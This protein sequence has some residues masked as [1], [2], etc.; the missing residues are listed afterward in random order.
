[1]SFRGR[2]VNCCNLTLEQTTEIAACADDG[3]P[4]QVPGVGWGKLATPGELGDQCGA[5]TTSQRGNVHQPAATPATCATMAI[6][7]G[8]RRALACPASITRKP[9]RSTAKN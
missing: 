2:I 5:A 6:G 8:R 4:L 7:S 1:M 9:V 3:W